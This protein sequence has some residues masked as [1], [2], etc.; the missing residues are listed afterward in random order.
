VFLSVDRYK[1]PELKRK[2]VKTVEFQFSKGDNPR[3]GVIEKNIESVFPSWRYKSSDLYQK[4][5]Y[6]RETKQ[7]QESV[8]SVVEKIKEK[9][10]VQSELSDM[11]SDI[12]DAVSEI[13]EEKGYRA[14]EVDTKSTYV[15]FSVIINTSMLDKSQ[16]ED[17]NEWFEELEATAVQAVEF[18]DEIRQKIF[19]SAY[20]E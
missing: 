15:D 18:R 1:Y 11:E 4:A 19:F 5:L 6:L 20:E 3:K 12:E 7:I 17:M 13:I 10:E 2:V 14:I 16:I 8:M 9:N